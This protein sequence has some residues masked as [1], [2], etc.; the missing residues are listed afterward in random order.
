MKQFTSK[1][2]LVRYGETDQMGV[3]HHSN[4]L[5]YF[6]VA[7]LEWLSA[8]GVSYASMEKEGLIMPVIDVK[9]TYKTP[10]LFDD[11]LTIYI[12]LSELPRVKIIFSYEIKNQK[13]EIVCTGET[14]LAFL[15]AKTRKPVRCPEEFGALFST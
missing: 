2:L 10:A 15:N 13:D 8:L 9:V 4:Y 11:S 14:T 3:V 5:R 6:E 1:P 12:F 7:R